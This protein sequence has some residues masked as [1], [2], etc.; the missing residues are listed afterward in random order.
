VKKENGNAAIKKF[1]KSIVG[2]DSFL[3]DLVEP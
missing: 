3:K 2:D 1:E